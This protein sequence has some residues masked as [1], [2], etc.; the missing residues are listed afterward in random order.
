MLRSHSCW[1]TSVVL[2]KPAHLDNLT[3]TAK[4]DTLRNMRCNIQLKLRQML[5][6]WLSNKANEIQG[7]ADRNDMKTFYNGLK[8]IYGPT[9]S[10]SS[11]LLSADGSSLISDKDKTLERWL[12]TSTVYSTA[13]P[14]STTRPL[15]VSHKFQSTRHWMPC[16]P[17]MRSRK[18][19][20]K[21]SAWLRLDSS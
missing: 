7:N 19:S 21:Q 6:F 5:E 4:K 20:P 14:P 15:T 3:S 8:E 13:H 18:Q 16:Q 1:K 11:P 12:N 10:G 2:T 9:P 17:L